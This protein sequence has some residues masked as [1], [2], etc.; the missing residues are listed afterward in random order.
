[1]T[2]AHVTVEVEVDPATAFDL[3]TRD[4]AAWW[5]ADRSLW[6]DSEGELRFEDGRGRQRNDLS[7]SREHAHL[8]RLQVNPGRMDLQIHPA[9]LDHP[10]SGGGF[11]GRQPTPD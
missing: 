7:G 11:A 2:E 9:P 5:R 4:I 8:N 10:V 3:F 1:M 6:G